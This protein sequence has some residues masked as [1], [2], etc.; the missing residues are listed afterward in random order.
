LS[1]EVLTVKSRSRVDSK[2]HSGLVCLVARKNRKKKNINEK[3]G[4]TYFHNELI[5]TQH[6]QLSLIN[7]M[8]SLD[9]KVRED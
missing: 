8:P 3:K 4:T 2:A 9:N 5:L 7:I 6:L 1:H